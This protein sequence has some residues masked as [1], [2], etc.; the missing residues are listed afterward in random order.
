MIKKW[1]YNC[2]YHVDGAIDDHNFVHQVFG[3]VAGDCLSL[4]NWRFI[5]LLRLGNFILCLSFSLFIFKKKIFK[6]TKNFLLCSSEFLRMN[7]RVSWW[8]VE[9]WL[10]VKPCLILLDRG[11]NLSSQEHV[12][13][14]QSC[15]WSSDLLRLGWPLAMSRVLDRSFLWKLGWLWSH[16]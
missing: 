7:S 4:D 16:V 2:A 15:C 12:D 5:L 11:F 6:N 1:D 10:A 8:S 3:A 13:F 9:V 14:Y